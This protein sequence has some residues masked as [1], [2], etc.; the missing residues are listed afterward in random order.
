M[1]ARTYRHPAYFSPRVF[2]WPRLPEHT[3]FTKVG[4]TSGP[5]F[6]VA[7]SPSCQNAAATI[8]VPFELTLAAMAVLDAFS[9]LFATPNRVA[10]TVLPAHDHEEYIHRMKR[11]STIDRERDLILATL[12][13]CG[14]SRNQVCKTLGI[15]RNLLNKKLGQYAAQGFTVPPSPKGWI[16]RE[17]RRAAR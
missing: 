7:S 8:R 13:Q 17:G 9:G 4:A 5:A 16:V 2:V 10:G 6:Q 11:I 1:T 3:R 12:S 14:G 15:H